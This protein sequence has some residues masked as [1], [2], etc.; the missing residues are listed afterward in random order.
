MQYF[1]LIDE[2]RISPFFMLLS[3]LFFSFYTSKDRGRIKREQIVEK[4]TFCDSF[5]F[6]IC[7]NLVIYKIKWIFFILPFIS[8]SL[9]LYLSFSLFSLSLSLILYLLFLFVSLYL[10]NSF[11]SLS[12]YLS[13]SLSFCRSIY[14]LLSLVE[15][16]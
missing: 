12:F 7:F 1:F 10:S 16:R 2:S 8:L 5:F 13:I 9:S 6:L 4:V 3:F 11:L 15:F 14:L